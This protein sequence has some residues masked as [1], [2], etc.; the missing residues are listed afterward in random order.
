MRR[1]FSVALFIALGPLSYAQAQSPVWAA[2][3]FSGGVDPIPFRMVSAPASFGES[4]PLVVFL[5]GAG[6]RGTDNERQLTHGKDRLAEAALRY[7]ATVIAPQCPNGDYWANVGREREAV[8]GRV[9]IDWAYRAHPTPALASVT[10]LVD[11][12]A[13]TPG[14]DSTQIHLVGISMGGMGIL[15]LACRQ[16]GR[17]A[18]V[19]SMAGSYGPQVAPILAQTPRLRFFHGDQDF[20]VHVDI[21]RELVRRL[22]SGG[23]DVEYV[24]FAGANHNS[25]D[26]AFA[27]ED[28]W[29]WLFGTR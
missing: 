8:T 14:V 9:S 1:L 27:R 13:R 18:S 20:V 5:H 3:Q 23:A 11:S 22:R 21:T 10:A 17:F 24:E 28:Y 26:P 12:L 7:G 19:T 15:E 16:N 6:E 4:R 2:H 25:W 29:D